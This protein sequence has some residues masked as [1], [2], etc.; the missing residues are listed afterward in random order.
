MTGLARLWLARLLLV[1]AGLL[2]RLAR[3]LVVL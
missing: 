1:L 2:T 3:K